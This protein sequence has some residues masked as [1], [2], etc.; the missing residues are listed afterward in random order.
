MSV[1]AM[2]KTFLPLLAA[3]AVMTLYSKRLAIAALG[4]RS[5]WVEHVYRVLGFAGALLLILLGGVLFLGSL[6]GSRPF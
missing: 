3:L 4:G 1:P 2:R 5:R 6:G